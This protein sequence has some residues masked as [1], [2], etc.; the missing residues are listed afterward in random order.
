MN[1]FEEV[2][3]K[4]DLLVSTWKYRV[5]LLSQKRYDVSRAIERL[6]IQ[7]SIFSRTFLMNEAELV[8]N[9]SYTQIV[10]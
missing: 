5:F 4:R 1:N 6:L 10:N 3:K 8:R 2:A 7:I 9:Y